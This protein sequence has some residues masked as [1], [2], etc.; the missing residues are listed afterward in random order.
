MKTNGRADGSM[1]PQG[2]AMIHLIVIIESTPS[3]SQAI[4]HSQSF[5]SGFLMPSLPCTLSLGVFVAPFSTAV[6]SSR[7]ASLLAFWNLL[8]AVRDLTKILAE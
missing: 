7:Q 6:S 4:P 8:E 1:S 3:R 2:L 5:L